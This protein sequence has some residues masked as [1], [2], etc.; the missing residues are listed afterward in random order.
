MAQYAIQKKQC[1]YSAHAF[2]PILFGVCAGLILALNLIAIEIVLVIV[3]VL[4]VPAVVAVLAVLA[5]VA[6]AVAGKL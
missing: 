1:N 6:V 4:I 2:L 3:L 5:V